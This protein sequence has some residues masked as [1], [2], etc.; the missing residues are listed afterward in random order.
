[1]TENRIL[2][3]SDE[4][5]NETIKDL[6]QEILDINDFDQQEELAQTALVE[7][8]RNYTREPIRLFINSVGG[9]V[10]DGLALVDTI[11]TSKTPVHTYCIGQ[12]MSVGFWIYLVGHKRFAGENCTF[13]YH[14]ISGYC[15][16]FLAYM[17][18]KVEEMQ[19]F[20]DMYDKCFKDN[21]KVTQDM[22]DYYKDKKENW[23]FGA[24]DALRMGVADDFYR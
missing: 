18:L 4:I 14:E 11:L 9:S 6:V 15:H 17:K 3:L 2:V 24:E 21:S 8:F 10:C 16:D 13:M 19:R 20:Q 12:A 5:N 23:Y 22:L 1:M 7:D